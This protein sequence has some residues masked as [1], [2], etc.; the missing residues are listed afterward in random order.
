[1]TKK[2]KIVLWSF[3]GGIFFLFTATASVLVATNSK[4]KSFQSLLNQRHSE[5]TG[6]SEQN[7]AD[8]LS[9]RDF[10]KVVSG[11]KLKPEFSNLTAETVYSLLQ[12]PSY[13]F[14]ILDII[15][16]DNKLD[17]AFEVKLNNSSDET[18][19][20][21]VENN[22]IKNLIIL[23]YK[24][25]TYS[26]QNLQD[27]PIFVYQT[28]FT[29]KGFKEDSKTANK[30]QN[31]SKSSTFAS[32]TQAELNKEQEEK[33]SKFLDFNI[34][35]LDS[36]FSVNEN[37]SNL[38]PSDFLKKLEEI[39]TKQKDTINNSSFG[40]ITLLGKFKLL[41]SLLDPIVL[42]PNQKLLFSVNSLKNH[43]YIINDREGKLLLEFNLEQDKK[44]INTIFLEIRGLNSI[45]D[46]TQEIKKD[47]SIF[48]NAYKFYNKFDINNVQDFSLKEKLQTKLEA[49]YYDKKSKKIKYDTNLIAPSELVKN[50]EDLKDFLQFN[51]NNI[52]RISSAYE[53]SFEPIFIENRTESEKE[54]IKNL[55]N[56]EGKVRADL[57]IMFKNKSNNI[58]YSS[59]IKDVDFK[60]FN[61]QFDNYLKL[62][63]D[64]QLAQL[65]NS[66][67]VFYIKPENKFM[68]ISDILRGLNTVIP[69]YYKNISNSNQDRWDKDSQFYSYSF[70]ELL[71]LNDSN[72]ISII[73]KFIENYFNNLLLDD[74]LNSSSRKPGY[75]IKELL[76]KVNNTKSNPLPKTFSPTKVNFDL[77]F[78]SVA[79]E[80]II[81]FVMSPEAD[82]YE[83]EAKSRQIIIKGFAKPN[84]LD[85]I[86]N[87]YLPTVFLD[88]SNSEKIPAVIEKSNLGFNLSPELKKHLEN[89]LFEFKNISSSA[90]DSV[91]Y[92]SVDTQHKTYFVNSDVLSGIILNNSGLKINSIKSD[93]PEEIQQGSTIKN[94]SIFFTFQLLDT[95]N[96]NEKHYILSSL[97][98]S[99]L[100][101]VALFIKKLDKDKTKDF[102]DQPSFVLGLEYKNISTNS[103]DTNNDKIN[104]SIV[105]VISSD[106]KTEVKPI[107]LDSNS[108]VDKSHLNISV[109]DSN[110]N[111]SNVFF[112]NALSTII[113]QIKVNNTQENSSLEFELRTKANK[114]NVYRSVLKTDNKDTKIKALFNRGIDF[115]VIGSNSVDQKS[116]IL[117]KS[118]LVFEHINQQDSEQI[119]RIL[120]EQYLK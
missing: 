34:S 107:T 98:D 37:F 91:S 38:L 111:F 1:M 24:N 67:N 118:L 112:A 21:K 88:A 66:D 110:K 12:D 48:P 62:E 97:K 103:T 46:L 55:A 60:L 33:D 8:Q 7:N 16:T 39:Y 104:E 82:G 109:L 100:G 114:D 45:K 32:N 120:S 93:S 49:K 26:E 59:I 35:F 51:T 31:A 17:L 80:L 101:E 74:H 29:L 36:Y 106:K 50:Q 99:K 52:R 56:Y 28:N 81:S 119:S 2:S 68:L 63:Y 77:R 40:L 105:A 72:K 5:P 71:R 86:K 92:S 75:I 94:G 85:Q 41:N 44:I 61:N 115:A 83:E 18:Q 108:A 3:L 76:R 84:L 78:D 43:S 102:S 15:D 116:S 22:T 11:F 23:A 64:A 20:T 113:L 54:T 87:N 53:V 27:K 19:Q 79:Q 42:K 73:F 65:H 57:N 47:L 58:T 9:A 6:L 89:H 10:E 4:R 25:K 70:K 90:T 14:N 30:T 96:D 117:F 95:I 69:S 13:S